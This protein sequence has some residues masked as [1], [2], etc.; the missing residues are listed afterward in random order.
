MTVVFARFRKYPRHAGM[1]PD[2]L[3]L[4]Y[5][6]SSK[7]GVEFVIFM[8]GFDRYNWNFHNIK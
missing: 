2:H 3:E 5:L 1:G 6:G 8:F 4:P 7:N